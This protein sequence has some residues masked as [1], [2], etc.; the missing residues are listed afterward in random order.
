MNKKNEMNWTLETVAGQAVVLYDS[1]REDALA[2]GDEQGIMFWEG[3]RNTALY[4][5]RG[6]DTP[7]TE[8]EVDLFVQAWN[9]EPADG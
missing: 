4:A 3:H 9:A 8:D 7:V 5:L 1:L 2:K 6:T